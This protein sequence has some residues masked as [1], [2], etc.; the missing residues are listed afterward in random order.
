METLISSKRD[1]VVGFFLENPT[2]EVHLRQLSRKLR[3]SLPWVR[4]TVEELARKG[5]VTRKK[6][7]GL[8]LVKAN[9]DN[10]LFLALK[11]SYN[12]CSLWDCGLVAFLMES[13]G[14]PETIVLFGSY[15]RGEDTESSDIDIAVVTTR[16]VS[17]DL[18]RFE[19]RLGRGVKV[20]RISRG[21]IEKDFLK[22]LANGIVLYGYLQ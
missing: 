5:F 14:R 17:V 15:S 18:A 11:R 21:K 16:K 8:V 13:Y 22:T 7:G 10:A 20:L 4:K 12:L 9:R 6:I 3:I 1:R 19:K 2:T